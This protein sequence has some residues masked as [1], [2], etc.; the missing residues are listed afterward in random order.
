MIDVIEYS[1]YEKNN[2]LKILE[3]RNNTKSNNIEDK[4]RNIIETVK[5]YGDRALINFTKQFDNIMLEDLRVTEDEIEE[6]YNSVDKEFIDIL[7]ES[8]ENIKAY[9]EKQK[10][11]DYIY[12]KENGVYMG[13]RIIPIESVGV[14]VPGGKAAYPSSV[15]M[16]V[17]PAKIAGVKKIVMVTPPS[18]NGEVN[19]NILAAA[20]ISGVD[21]VFKVGGAQAIA[22]LAY[23]TET[24]EAVCTIVGPGNAYVA[25]AKRQVYG[26]VGIDMI[27]GPSEVLIIADE[28]AN[29]KFIAADLMAQAE[30]DEMASSILITTSMN[31]A[32][33]VNNEV[34]VKVEDLDRKEIVKKSLQSYGKIIVCN[35]IDECIDIS[36][37]ISPEHLEILLKN[38]IEYLEKIKNAGS[39]FLGEYTPEP[40]GDYFA[41]TNHVLP[42]CRSARFSS[43]LSLDTFTKKSSYLYYSK[44][45][46]LNC[47]EKVV[48]FA[49]EEGLTA[50]GNSIKVRLEYEEN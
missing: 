39:I 25:E 24:I 28:A 10:K 43:P 44:E 26:K 47:G 50:H 48:K 32:K 21:E 12:T 19:K 3:E 37:K 2:L 41:G 5:D 14:Y 6:A 29:E 46:L 4:V 38:P 45:A 1:K 49:K 16:N 8:K 17:I 31:L 11:L 13:Q 42:T 23:G 40:M 30:H 35:N 15:L 22:A 27:A 34:K 18:L 36:N 7:K 20:K 9:H 33:K